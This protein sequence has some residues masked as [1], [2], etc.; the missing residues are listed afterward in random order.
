MTWVFPEHYD[1]YQTLAT[2]PRGRSVCNRPT[3][4][5]ARAP[6]PS[7][8]A[9]RTCRWRMS[10]SSI[11]TPRSRWWP[12]ERERKWPRSSRCRSWRNTRARTFAWPGRSTK[13]WPGAT[14]TP[15]STKTSSAP[16][17]SAMV[18]ANALRRYLQ[19][20]PTR[21]EKPRPRRTRPKREEW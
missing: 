21:K 10:L 6:R 15:R 16:I 3:R 19:S 5:T 11:S 18:S 1:P 2:P 7:S 13:R 20:T 17:K 14:S 12:G 8:T 9:W 4:T